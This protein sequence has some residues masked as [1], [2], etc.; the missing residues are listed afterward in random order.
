[1]QK[2]VSNGA[3]GEYCKTLR[4]TFNIKKTIISESKAK[5]NSLFKTDTQM[6]GFSN[7]KIKKAHLF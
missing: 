6:K 5:R 7:A 3:V 2:P 4:P 1:M